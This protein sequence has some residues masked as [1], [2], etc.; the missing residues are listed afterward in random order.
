MT[1]G[2]GKRAMKVLA[3]SSQKGGVGKSTS[4]LYLSDRAARLLGP[5]G[6]RVALIDRDESKNLTRLLEIQPWAHP[7]GV[8]LL[9]GMELPGLD[10]GYALTIIDTPPG[11]SAIGSL[12]EA[13]LVVV[14]VLP[15]TQGVNTLIEFL[16]NIEAQRITTSPS[17]RLVAL[18]P[19]MV[20]KRLVMHQT[21]L[22]D[23]E[24]I[25]TDHEPP[26]LVLPSIARSARVGRCEL[27][28]PE[29]DAAAGALFQAI[30]LTEDV[31]GGVH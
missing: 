11:L 5:S 16:Q 12:R 7:S 31:A 9:D 17:M 3:C 1:S 15:E 20:Q 6:G 2:E 21:H 26:L 28:A 4:A 27:S 14:P 10:D 19:T 30:H 29:Y 24:H 22:D 18:L 25:A 23:I 8:D 13:N